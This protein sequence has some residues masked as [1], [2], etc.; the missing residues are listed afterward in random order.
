VL[1]RRNKLRR[2]QRAGTA[3]SKAAGAERVSRAS[4]LAAGLAV[5]PDPGE[6]AASVGIA[7]VGDELEDLVALARRLYPDVAAGR[8]EGTARVVTRTIHLLA[9][10]LQDTAHLLAPRDLATAARQLGQIREVLV[11]REGAREQ[12]TSIEVG[13]MGP[14]NRLEPV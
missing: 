1:E 6:A 13:I 5:L 3:E 8:V 10:Q 4:R 12:W 2:A 14:D 9:Q 11:G 7:A